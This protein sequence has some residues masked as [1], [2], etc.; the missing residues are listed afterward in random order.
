MSKKYQEAVHTADGTTYPPALYKIKKFRDLKKHFDY[1]KLNNILIVGEI[2]SFEDVLKCFCPKDIN[3]DDF[4]KY[5]CFDSDICYYH[6]DYSP[7]DIDKLLHI[8]SLPYE[9]VIALQRIEEGNII[10]DTHNYYFL[11]D[12]NSGTQY[13][14]RQLGY[15]I[16][17]DHQVMYSCKINQKNNEILFA[18]KS[19]TNKIREYIINDICKPNQLTE[20]KILNIPNFFKVYWHDLL[21][22]DDMIF[23]VKG[24]RVDKATYLGNCMTFRKFYKKYLK[25]DPFNYPDQIKNGELAQPIIYRIGKTSKTASDIFFKEILKD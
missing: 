13:L 5:I 2:I 9:I 23:G 6:N 12:I 11:S 16:Y 8:S 10:M 22:P 20:E 24:S 7:I 15:D 14:I 18:N 17:C 4:F 25:T 1:E 19:Q 21:L 3:D